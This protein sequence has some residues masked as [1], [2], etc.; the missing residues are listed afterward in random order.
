MSSER[1]AVYCDESSHL[2]NDGFPTMSMGAIWC[3]RSEVK[4]AGQRIREIK[5]RHGMAAGAEIKWTK[6]SP[7]GLSLYIELVDYFFDNDSLAFRVLV[8]T[9]KNKLAHVNFAQT[10]D[11][12]F[13]KMYFLLLNNIIQNKSCYSIFIDQKDTRSREKVKH[14]SDVLANANYDFSREII[15][16]VQ[17]VRSDEVP[18]MQLT[19]LLL[20]AVSSIS[21]GGPLSIAKSELIK[22]IQKRSRYSLRRSTTLAERKFNVFYWTPQDHHP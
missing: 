10:H 17:T 19:D 21:R 1:Y 5:M 15:E 12:W 8:A 3:P 16:R 4:E 14:L 13:Y 11:E 2:P 20:G 6:I 18:L 9:S 22:R 7:A